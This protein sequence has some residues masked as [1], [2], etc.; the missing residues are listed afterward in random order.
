[1]PRRNRYVK[2]IGLRIDLPTLDKLDALSDS[3]DLDRSG[4]IRKLLDDIEL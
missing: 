4:T 2:F 1:M 3:L